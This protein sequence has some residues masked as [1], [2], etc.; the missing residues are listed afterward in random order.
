MK[1][2]SRLL[3]ILLLAVAVW[4][5]G[6]P[7]MAGGGV[8]KVTSVSKPVSYMV[9]NAC[10]KSFDGFVDVAYSPRT[11]DN[12]LRAMQ[13]D[14]DEG[15]VAPFYSARM[16]LKVYI[17]PTGDITGW[18]PS[19]NGIIGEGF[20]QWEKALNGKVCFVSTQDPVRADITMEWVERITSTSQRAEGVTFNINRQGYAYRAY[21]QVETLNRWNGEPYELEQTRT[22]VIH[23]IGHAL[24]LGHSDQ[25]T[26]VMYPVAH[27]VQ[28]VSAR[29]ANTIRALY[30]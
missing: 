1:R 23:E 25:I 16:P 3:P 11:S 6:A 26:D 20:R 12:Y 2:L 21:I 7:A 19:M 27:R 14:V 28:H 29:D 8:Y 4:L 10:K 15:A 22:A 18:D 9:P 17:K 30:P 24:G 13:A 5:S